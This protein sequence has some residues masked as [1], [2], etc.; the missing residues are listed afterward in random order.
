MN[1]SEKACPVPREQRPLNEYLTLKDSVFFFWTIKPT[2]SY[3]KQ[4]FLFSVIVYPTIL[5]IVRSSGELNPMYIFFYTLVFGTILLFF[6]FLRFYLAW[7]YIYKRL[8]DATISY[9]ESGWYDCQTWIKSPEILVQD[10]LIAQYELL[11][12]LTRLK[13]TLLTLLFIILSSLF[14]IKFFV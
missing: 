8:I 6:F 9:E 4:L 11:P 5:G 14:Y 1:L 10:T 13:E 3:I 2:I 7:L 12:I